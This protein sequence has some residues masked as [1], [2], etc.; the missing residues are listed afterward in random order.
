MHVQVRVVYRLRIISWLILWKSSASLFSL[1]RLIDCPSLVW[2]LLCIVR[3]RPWNLFSHLARFEFNT[4][5]SFLR[6]SLSLLFKLFIF[7]YFTLTLLIFAYFLAL[8]YYF[9]ALTFTM[10]ALCVWRQFDFITANLNHFAVT[11]IT[12]MAV[13]LS[14]YLAIGHFFFN[15]NYKYY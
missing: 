9:D 8:L 15:Y 3:R 6:L 11:F 12:V 14:R 4:I 1:A 2:L 5:A 13:D 7:L 10:I